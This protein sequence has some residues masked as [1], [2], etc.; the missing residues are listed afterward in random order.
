MRIASR[1]TMTCNFIRHL[2][3]R[4]IVLDIVDAL[5]HS[6]DGQQVVGRAVGL[7]KRRGGWT[8]RGRGE[9]RPVGRWGDPTT[10]QHCVKRRSVWQETLAA[11]ERGKSVLPKSLVRGSD[12][13]PTSIDAHVCVRWRE[14]GTVL[15]CEC[16]HRIECSQGRSE[17]SGR[18]VE[19][20]VVQ[21]EREEVRWSCGQGRGRRAE[22][23]VG[24]GQVCAALSVVVA[25]LGDLECGTKAV[26]VST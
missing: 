7:M 26:S 19:E 11:V 1:R 2:V 4:Q 16:Q 10:W 20:V 3:V 24:F 22:G 15:G 18:S 13:S 12:A 23:D 9:R 8:D 6:L 25:V 14:E 5:H 17:Q 21:V